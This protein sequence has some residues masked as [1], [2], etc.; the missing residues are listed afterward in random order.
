VQSVIFT[1]DRFSHQASDAD[2]KARAFFPIRWSR[3]QRVLPAKDLTASLL[4]RFG[5]R[6]EAAMNQSRDERMRPFQT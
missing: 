6:A 4:P 3:D 5:R 1:A 2:Q